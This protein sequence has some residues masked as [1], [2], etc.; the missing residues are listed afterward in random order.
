REKPRRSRAVSAEPFSPATV[1]KRANTLVFLPIWLKSLALVYLAMSPVTVKVPCAPAPLACTT[2]SGMRSRLNWA[3]FSKRRESSIR[4]GPLG[5]AVTEFWLSPTGRPDDVVINGQ[6][7]C[8]GL[9]VFIGIPSNYRRF[10]VA[11]R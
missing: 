6:D 11:G 9:S 4:T 1:E 8:S 10:R 2:R 5:P 7:V 3:I